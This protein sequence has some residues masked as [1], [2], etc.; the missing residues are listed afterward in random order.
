VERAAW[1]QVA[2]DLKRFAGKEIVVRL[3]NAANNWDYEFG[4]WSALEL[5]VRPQGTAASR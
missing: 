2:V 5:D 1:N 3:E 4:Y